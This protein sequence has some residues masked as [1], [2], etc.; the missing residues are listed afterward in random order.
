MRILSNH[1]FHFGRFSLSRS[2]IYDIAQRA[3]VSPSTVSRALQDHPRIGVKTRA[4][5]QALAEEMGYIPSA[6]ARGL[7]TN[8]SRVLGVIAHRIED[9]FLIEV[10]RGIEDTLHASGYSLFLAASH[11]DPEREREVMHAMS[12]RRVDGIIISS[13]HVNLKRLHQLD[14]YG[15]P[16]VL[17]NNQAMWKPDTHSVCHDEIYAMNQLLQH[18][19]DLG[20]QQ[21]AYLGNSRGGR[22]NAERLQGYK[23][24]LNQAELKPNKAYISNGQN[25]MPQGGAQGMRNLLELKERPTALV[26]YNDMMAIGAIQTIH[27]AGLRVPEDISVTGFDN[28]DLAAYTTPPLTTFH[29]PRYELGQQAATMMLNALNEERTSVQP[30]VSILRGELI[31]RQSTTSPIKREK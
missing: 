14:K 26:C 16:S 17:I 5:I 15:V 2:T 11:H 27:Q 4:R 20:H 7:T 24:A 25:G 10:L 9:P 3:E 22:T 19:M 31:V 28:I 6:I 1:E 23:E 18:V 13:S 29:Q 30:Q 21:I 8:R 12:E